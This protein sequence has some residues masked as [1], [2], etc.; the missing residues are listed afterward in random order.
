MRSDV[1]DEDLA[2]AARMGDLGSF[3]TLVERHRGRIFSLALRMCGNPEEAEDMAQEAFLKVYRG[4]PSFRGEAAFTTWMLR[5]ALNTFHRHLRRLPRTQ[6]LPEGPARPE[7]ESAG[8]LPDAEVLGSE[9]DE[10]VRQMVSRLPEPFRD[11]VT[12]F[13]L[14]ERSVEEAAA[15]LGVSLGTLKSRLFRGRGMLLDA[16]PAETA[17]PAGNKNAQREERRARGVIP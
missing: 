7:V 2:R 11:A 3:R 4:L 13:Y 12:L 1:G 5:V 9:R 10:T 6:P 14:Q 17:A 15:A 8:P 16:W